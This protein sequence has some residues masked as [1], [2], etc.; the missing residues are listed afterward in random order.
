MYF[1]PLWRFV[2]EYSDAA[3]VSRSGDGSWAT[4]SIERCSGLGRMRGIQRDS[5]FSPEAADTETVSAY[6]TAYFRGDVYVVLPTPLFT[7]K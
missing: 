4:D 2:K 7:T 3:A 5:V 6:C 1:P